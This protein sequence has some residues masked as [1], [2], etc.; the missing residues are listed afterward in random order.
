[1][2]II[3]IS[4]LAICTLHSERPE[5]A[6]IIADSVQFLIAESATTADLTSLFRRR[7]LGFLEVTT[8]LDCQRARC[9]TFV[10]RQLDGK[11]LTAA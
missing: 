5:I 4:S 10:A 3:R 2:P 11:G 9:H 1:L 6:A 7:R 8:E